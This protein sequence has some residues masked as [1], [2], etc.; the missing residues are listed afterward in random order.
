MQIGGVDFEFSIRLGDIIIMIGGLFVGV[1]T[2]YGIINK[3][4]LFG[5]RMDIIDAS[6]ED[7]QK[8]V[9]DAT[10][11]AISSSRVERLERDMDRAQQMI[12][13]LQRGRGYVQRE[14]A[15]EWVR[16]GRTP[17]SCTDF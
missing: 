9:K 7:L 17:D 5:Y 13:E 2:Y 8:D 12:F 15:G 3:L 1:K 11:R 14:I 16:T 4:N 6:V 10:T